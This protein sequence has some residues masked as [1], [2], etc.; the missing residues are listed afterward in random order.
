MD[1]VAAQSSR[2]VKEDGLVS[3][4]TCLLA[5]KPQMGKAPEGRKD[6]G[7]R[8]LQAGGPCGSVVGVWVLEPR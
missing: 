2:R 6:L 7:I 3:L 1:K 8:L 4:E 5:S